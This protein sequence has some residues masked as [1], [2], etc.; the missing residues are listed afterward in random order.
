MSVGNVSNQNGYAY[1][2][3]AGPPVQRGTN[4]PNISQESKPTQ[5]TSNESFRVYAGDSIPSNVVL[6]PNQRKQLFEE[7]YID[8]QRSSTMMESN[9]G[10]LSITGKLIGALVGPSKSVAAISIDPK[11]LEMIKDPNAIVGMGYTRVIS[12]NFTVL[13]PVNSPDRPESTPQTPQKTPEKALDINIYQQDARIREQERLTAEIVGKPEG[14]ED[15]FATGMTQTWREQQLNAQRTGNVTAFMQNNNSTGLGNMMSFVG[16]NK[17]DGQNIRAGTPQY[18]QLFTVSRFA[19]GAS[20]VDGTRY[21]SEMTAGDINNRMSTNSVAAIQPDRPAMYPNLPSSPSKRTDF[22]IGKE[23][24]QNRMDGSH[25]EYGQTYRFEM[26]SHLDEKPNGKPKFPVA[27]NPRLEGEFTRLYTKAHPGATPDQINA[28]KQNATLGD[29]VRLSNQTTTIGNGPE[30]A[31]TRQQYVHLLNE[32]RQKNGQPADFTEANV[33][34]SQVTQAEYYALQYQVSSAYVSSPQAHVPPMNPPVQ[35][36]DNGRVT[37]MN[38]GNIAAN[39]NNLA[40]FSMTNFGRDVGQMQ[41]MGNGLIN[42]FVDKGN[43]PSEFRLERNDA[44]DMTGTAEQ[45]NNIV[46]LTTSQQ[47]QQWIADRGFTIAQNGT[48]RDQDGKNVSMVPENVRVNMLKAIQGMPPAVRNTPQMQRLFQGLE[49]SKVGDPA[50]VRSDDLTA[51]MR[52]T[53]FVS[54]MN[55]N[56][57]PSKTLNQVAQPMDV[58]ALTQGQWAQMQGLKATDSDTST[59]GRSAAQQFQDGQYVFTT[60][61]TTSPQQPLK[62]DNITTGQLAEMAKSDPAKFGRVMTEVFKLT[63]EQAAEQKQLAEQNPGAWTMPRLPAGS[64]ATQVKETLPP[65]AEDQKQAATT[66]LTNNIATLNTLSNY[67]NNGL[68]LVGGQAK[69]D[70]LVAQINQDLDK[71]I[72][73]DPNA[74]VK[75]MDGNPPVEKTMKAS[76]LKAH[77]A[78]EATTVKDN[79]EKYGRASALM[80]GEDG[81]TTVAPTSDGASTGRPLAPIGVPTPPSLPD[82]DKSDYYKSV[83]GYTRQMSTHVN[84]LLTT[85]KRHISD[86][87]LAGMRQ[88]VNQMRNNLAESLGTNPDALS[89]MANEPNQVGQALGIAEPYAQMSPEN[90]EKVDQALSSISLLNKAQANLGL[91]ADGSAL[92]VAR[93]DMAALRSN[94]EN[95]DISVTRNAFKGELERVAKDNPDAFKTIVQGAYGLA[96]NDPKIA[97]LLTLA[98]NGQMPE[99]PNVRFVDAGDLKG[100]NAA[101]VNEGGGTILLSRELLTRQPFSAQAVQ[102]AFAEEMFHHLERTVRP[103]G[104]DTAGDEGRGGLQAL[105]AYREDKDNLQGISTAGAKGR[106]EQAQGVSTVSSGDHGTVTLDGRTVAAEFNSGN[107]YVTAP[108]TSELYRDNDG[109][110]IANAQNSDGTN[111]AQRF[112]DADIRVRNAYA[113]GVTHGPDHN[114]WSTHANMDA[115][116]KLPGATVAAND[117]TGRVLNPTQKGITLEGGEPGTMNFT[118]GAEGDTGGKLKMTL[119]GAMATLSFGLADKAFQASAAILNVW[120]NEYTVNLAKDTIVGDV[121]F[122]KALNLT[123]GLRDHQHQERA[124]TE[125]KLNPDTWSTTPDYNAANRI[126]A[127][128]ERKATQEAYLDQRT[129]AVDNSNRRIKQE[130]E[131]ANKA[132]PEQAVSNPGVAQPKETQN[133]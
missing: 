77:I 99:P 92:Q 120:K 57:V 58:K 16:G 66:A 112:N 76:E 90:K 36:G 67:V 60:G 98:Q 9:E 1:R 128:R 14:G 122:D 100:G 86:Q 40:Y 61:S 3:L 43:Y 110:G 71:L 39:S 101:Y 79:I 115:K 48:L 63:P 6:N 62:V 33:D 45:F 124:I 38:S 64:S 107:P 132:Q 130:L 87:D 73:I 105:R 69:A 15:L 24:M 59:D 106:D 13:P 102:D 129:G 70:A 12:E 133:A 34:F 31:Q 74:E 65:S 78:S 32:V 25:K 97:E 125:A 103:D 26:L 8:V 30:S 11:F 28:A 111:N 117:G 42:E 55:A 85:G 126:A 72:A 121:L 22:M 93:A 49:S 37:N 2:N 123:V 54:A 119:M 41:F 7:G 35:I 5:A 118:Q 47:G 81:E 50:F 18:N 19:L 95:F 44:Q 56:N 4:A 75:F 89:I 108:S 23:F 68:N 116:G 27:G 88:S 94:I 29:V 52:D 82:G 109:D 104:S 127:A 53:R 46:D 84:S 20:F 10:L 131:H 51:M 91:H 96:E 80:Q 17:L 114:Q 113:T 21:N 83:E